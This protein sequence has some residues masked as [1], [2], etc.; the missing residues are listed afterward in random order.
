VIRGEK[1]RR[2]TLCFLGD[3]ALNQGSF[4]EAMNLAGILDL[5]IVFVC[6]NN[7]YSMGTSIRRGTTMAHDI[8]RKADGYGMES[9]VVDGMD[10]LEVYRGLKPLA[11]RCRETSRPA[12]V[13]V[14]T[15]RYKGHSMSDPRK[16]RT[17]DEEARY[18]AED[19]IDRLVKHLIAKHG[20]TEEEHAALAR[21]VTHEVREAIKWADASPPPDVGEL[22]TDVYTQAW[23]PYR[24]TRPPQMLSD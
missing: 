18:E 8:C 12:F 3:G 10:V 21:D 7:G 4:H 9:L 16:Y 19:P 2:L 11:D 5:P 15:Y 24:G 6:E 13:D 22:Y 1:S 17:K 20:F 23:G 14:R